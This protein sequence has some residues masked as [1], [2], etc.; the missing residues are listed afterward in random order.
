MSPLTN[1]ER[2][3]LLRLARQALDT[4]L[5]TL[6]SGSSTIDAARLPAPL[7]ARSGVFVTLRNRGGELRGCVGYLEPRYPLYRG[8]MEAAVGAAAR[9]PRFAPLT[10]AELPEIELEI[11]I[12]SPP[13]PIRADQI[14]I[15]FHGLV[16]TEG[17]S[18]GL[19]LPQVARA[20]NWGPERFLEETCRKAGLAPDAWRQSARVEGFQADVFG[21]K[22]LEPGGVRRSLL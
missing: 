21:E 22:L 3:V 2:Q 13:A 12:L 16:V 8:V 5:G 4:Q 9:D 1:D 20:Q 18:R 19:L 6:R 15:G 17:L 11:S 14:R 10:S 7:Q